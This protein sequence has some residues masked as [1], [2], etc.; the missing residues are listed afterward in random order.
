[1]PRAF[2]LIELLVVIAIIAILIGILMPALASARDRA[3][4]IQCLANLR[5]LGQATVM[6]SDDFQGHLPLNSHSP[7]QS[8]VDTLVP[9]G[10]PDN[11]RWCP[12]DPTERPTSFAT[13]NFLT[14]G[15]NPAESWTRLHH[16]PNPTATALAVEAAPQHLGDHIHPRGWGTNPNWSEPEHLLTE[17]DV[18]RHFSASHVLYVA[19]QAS[20]LP[21]AT[22]Q[23]T[24]TADRN[25]FHPAKAR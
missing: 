5:T 18:E 11:A 6:Y 2:T 12:L 3:N 24:F 19:G 25:L 4:A 9:Y 22:I 17:I 15:P 23:Q 21:W 14:P 20:T 7:G 10:V 1:M 13:N 8:W 16:I